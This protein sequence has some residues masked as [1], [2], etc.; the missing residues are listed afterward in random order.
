MLQECL[1]AKSSSAQYG[2]WALKVIA[3]L[4]QGEEIEG[5]AA[6]N[7]FQFMAASIHANTFTL[8]KINPA[9]VHEKYHDF[10]LMYVDHRSLGATHWM[11]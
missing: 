9:C 2:I 10:T 6:A 5:Q 7:H 8:P 11:P 3:A 4:G 1:W